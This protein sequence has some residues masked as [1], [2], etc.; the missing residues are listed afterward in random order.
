MAW[1]LARLLLVAMLVAAPATAKAGDPVTQAIAALNAARTDNG[2]ALVQ[3][4]PQLS[5][6]ARL[7]IADMVQR[8]YFSAD[9]P[10]R[11]A[12]RDWF[13]KSGFVPSATDIVVYAGA[14][15]GSLLIETLLD[16]APFRKTL[17]DR[18]VGEIGIGHRAGAYRAGRKQIT[19]AWVVVMARTRYD[20]V[21]NAEADLVRAVNRARASRGLPAVAPAPGLMAAAANHAHDMVARGF[22]AHRAPDG[23]DVGDRAHQQNYRYRKVGENLAAGITDP[24]DVVQGWTDS[25]GHAAVM[26]DPAFRELGVGYRTGP[27]TEPTRSLGQ[28]WVAV[29]GTRQ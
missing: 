7:H 29:F 15:D 17:L 16:D 10:G 21:P 8:G 1:S 2:L 14:P 9:P 23:K 19:D 4:R 26:Y 18:H 22:F 6:A 28:I 12:F 25:P 24:G 5:A 3:E 20:P 13:V 27:V 11:A